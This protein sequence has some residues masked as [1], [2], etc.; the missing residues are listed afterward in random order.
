M[1]GIWCISCF[2]SSI[3]SLQ[4]HYAFLCRLVCA[5]GI[6]VCGGYWVSLGGEEDKHKNMRFTAIV[7][8][9]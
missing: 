6:V 3:S 8:A 2:F 9:F 5:Y 4:G 7:V 1:S